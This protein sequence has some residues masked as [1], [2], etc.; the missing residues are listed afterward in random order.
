MRKAMEKDGIKH[1]DLV[2]A[3]EWINPETNID[4]H[5]K[6]TLITSRTDQ[7]IPTKYQE[8]YAEKLQEANVEL[9]HIRKNTGHAVTIINFCLNP[10]KYF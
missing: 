1:E 2:K 6:M 4:V 3:W 5:N 8:K 7:V 10:N 9:T